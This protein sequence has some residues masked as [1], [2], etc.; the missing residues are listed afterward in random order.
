MKIQNPMKSLSMKWDVNHCQVRGAAKCFP[1]HTFL[2]K[3]IGIQIV[4]DMVWIYIGL[5]HSL[6]G[7]SYSLFEN[8]LIFIP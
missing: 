3:L 2:F 6:D 7:G 4:T 8:M 5:S 1:Y